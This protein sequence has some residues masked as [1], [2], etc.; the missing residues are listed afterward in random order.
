MK[1]KIRVVKKF[2]L[3]H[4][5]KFRVV[6]NFKIVKR[7]CSLNKY[8]RVAA[9]HILNLVSNLLIQ[10]RYTKLRS[11]SLKQ[12]TILVSALDLF[13]LTEYFDNK[14]IWNLLSYFMASCILNTESIVLIDH[15]LTG[16]LIHAFKFFCLLHYKWRHYLSTSKQIEMNK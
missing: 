7:S 12:E 2:H 15:K 11:L 14:V 3:V 8:Y 13:K 5:K 1:K 4:L 10:N 6:K 16:L 9:L